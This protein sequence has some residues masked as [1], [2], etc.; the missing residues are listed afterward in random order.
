MISCF[1]HSG[2][3]KAQLGRCAAVHS[4]IL[5]QDGLELSIFGYDGIV[6]EFA[7]MAM[8][9]VPSKDGISHHKAEFT[10]MADIACGAELL[11][12]TLFDLANMEV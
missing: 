3:K 11:A 8:I 9:F 2:T 6:A 10:E 1:L 5:R 7:P 4:F 12:N